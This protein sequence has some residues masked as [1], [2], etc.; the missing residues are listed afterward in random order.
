MIRRILG[1][2]ALRA[3]GWRI[4]GTPPD[5]EHVGILLAA[6]HTSNWDF[7]IMLATAWATQLHPKY[8]A[9]KELFA[10]PTKIVIAGTGGIATDRDD[11]GTLVADLVRR[12][13]SG[14][15]F[16]LVM[17]PE[18]TRKASAGWKSGFYRIAREADIP[19][20][21]CSVD[22]RTREIWFGPT[23]HLTGDVQA[24]MDRMR[25]F[26]AD[27]AGVRP[28]LKSPVRLSVEARRGARGHHSGRP[29]LI[30]R[31]PA[32]ARRDHRGAAEPA[33]RTALT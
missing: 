11:P 29:R 9:K 26:Y 25:A 22:S 3:T 20:T 16:I 5:P 2:T 23:F 10:R 1:K 17:A 15:R 4:H 7:P 13:R 19:V 8:L 28:S 24:D 21:A 12:A 6:P 33:V 27:K 14:E 30:P 32:P 31:R 18:G